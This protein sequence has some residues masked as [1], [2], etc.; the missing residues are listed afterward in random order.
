VVSQ[1]IYSLRSGLL[2]EELVLIYLCGW[3]VDSIFSTQIGKSSS[4][5]FCR[6]FFFFRCLLTHCCNCIIHPSIGNLTKMTE[7]ALDWRRSGGSSRKPIFCDG[8]SSSFSVSPSHFVLSMSSHSLLPM[9]YTSID[10]EFDANCANA[11]R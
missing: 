6:C 4:R 3:L 11:L 10:V 1:I 2:L 7:I 9:Y 8:V 5:P